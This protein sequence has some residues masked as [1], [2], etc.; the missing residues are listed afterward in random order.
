VESRHDVL[1]TKRKRKKRYD[2]WSVKGGNGA[3]LVQE[4]SSFWLRRGE[5]VAVSPDEG[6]SYWVTSNVSTK[7]REV[8]FF[9]TEKSLL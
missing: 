3:K 5:E 9:N 4:G 1:V 6:T 7:A 8:F 2:G